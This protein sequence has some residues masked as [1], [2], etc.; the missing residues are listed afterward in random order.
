MASS[1]LDSS[2][3]AF[4]DPSWDDLRIFLAVVAHG[5]MNAAA[6]A[7]GQSQPTVARRVKALEEALGLSLFQRGPNNLELTEAGR[8]LLEAALP[9]GEAAAAVTRTAAA[10]R[11]DPD[12]PVRVTATASVTMFLSLHAAELHEAAAPV[13][14]A[15]IPT[16]QRLDLA[17]GE[18]DIGLR[19]R[20]LPEGTDDLVARR[21]GRIAFAIYARTENPEAV[22]APPEDP[23]LSR[24]AAYVADFAKGRTIAARIGDMP[25]RYQAAKAGLGAAFLPCWLGDADPDLVQVLKPEGDLVEDVFLVMHRRSRSRPNVTR[26]ADALAALFKRNQKALVGG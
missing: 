8:A 20:N 9:M 5:S 17:S 24:Q 10:Y 25:I 18:A 3:L 7:L 12:A 21:I 2:R 22:I 11:P 23:T 16:R 26:V 13:E 4:A 6:R 1:S 14:I 19:M 15:Y